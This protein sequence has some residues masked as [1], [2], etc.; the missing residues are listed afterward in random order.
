MEKFLAVVVV[1]VP[2]PG[3]L[4]VE[5]DREKAAR[6]ASG[7]E[8]PKHR[9]DKIPRRVGPPVMLVREADLVGE[10]RVAEDD[11]KRGFPLP[12]FPDPVWVKLRKTRGKGTGKDFFVCRDPL[13]T[14]VP[15]D[16]RNVVRDPAL[17]RPHPQ[18]VAAEDLFEKRDG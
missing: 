14:V 3:V 15:E 11:C 10:L 13:D 12:L 4:S 6:F 18:G 7:L 5:D 1:P 16:P 17:R 2:F 8:P 9:V